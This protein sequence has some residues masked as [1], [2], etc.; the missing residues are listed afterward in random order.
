MIWKKKNDSPAAPGAATADSASKGGPLPF[1][2]KHWKIILVIVCAAAVG[3]YFLFGK[4]QAKPVNVVPYTHLFQ[5]KSC[6]SQ[7]VSDCGWW[8]NEFPALRGSVV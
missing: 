8:T 1:V 4:K 7:V 5:L 2:K 6:L 3:G